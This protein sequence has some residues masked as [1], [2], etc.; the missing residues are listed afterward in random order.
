MRARSLK[1]TVDLSVIPDVQ[2]TPAF[3]SA[4]VQRIRHQILF[5]LDHTFQWIPFS[6]SYSENTQSEYPVK[7]TLL[8]VHPDCFHENRREIHLSRIPHYKKIDMELTGKIIKN[9]I[10]QSGIPVRELSRIL[11][12]R[13]RTS[14][15]HW[16]QGGSLPSVE[17]LYRLHIFL[18]CHM[19][20]LL[21]HVG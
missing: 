10:H 18:N 9:R 21:S 2:F 15:Y 3:V 6:I 5:P 20:E 4:I 14:V 1:I 16:L 17:H 11:G 13:A 8:R 19:E 12:L 7:G